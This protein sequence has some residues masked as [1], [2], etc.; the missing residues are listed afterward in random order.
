MFIFMSYRKSGILMLGIS[1][2]KYVLNVFEEEETCCNI[3][4]NYLMQ[5]KER[6]S[7]RVKYSG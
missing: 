6:P 3:G 5:W 2:Y 1:Q 7:S 4:I